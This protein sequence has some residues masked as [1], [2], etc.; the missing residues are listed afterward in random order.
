M[1]ALNVSTRTHAVT[2]ALE[3]GLL[4]WRAGDDGLADRQ[5]NLRHTA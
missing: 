2:K 4:S 5:G 3:L 1:K